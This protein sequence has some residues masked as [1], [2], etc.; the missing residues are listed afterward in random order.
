MY[1]HIKPSGFS[2]HSTILQRDSYMH[3]VNQL[4]VF[5]ALFRDQWHGGLCGSTC[6][7]TFPHWLSLMFHWPV[8]FLA[9]SQVSSIHI[10][11]VILVRLVINPKSLSQMSSWVENIWS[12]ADWKFK[13]TLILF[14]SNSSTLC[15]LHMLIL[16]WR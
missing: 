8:R 13:Q 2:L 7:S 16:W 5:N 11:T 9:S 10:C 6:D 14:L 12:V 1:S 4:V 15:M 3:Y